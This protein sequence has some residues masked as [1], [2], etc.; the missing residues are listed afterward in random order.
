MRLTLTREALAGRVAVYTLALGAFLSAALLLVCLV[1][2]PPNPISPQ[3]SPAQQ[4]NFKQVIPE[5]WAFFTLS[6]RQ[7]DFVLFKPSG[8]NG[9]TSGLLG[10]AS[11]PSQLFGWSRLSRAQG[12]DLGVVS[13]QVGQQEYSS[14][15]SASIGDCL[16]RL[17]PLVHVHNFASHPLVCG[18][19]L[20]VWRKL[21]P[22]NWSTFKRVTMHARVANLYVECRA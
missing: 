12:F 11:D 9:W 10:P 21:V 22:W 2:L 15:D 17:P 1:Y 20:L 8:A 4:Q 18:R 13:S 7:E 3:W 6:L 19:A 14:C 16:E 5:A